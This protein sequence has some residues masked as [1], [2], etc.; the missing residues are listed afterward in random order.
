MREQ[1]I[2]LHPF[3]GGMSSTAIIPIVRREPPKRPILKKTATTE[4]TKERGDSTISEQRSRNESK[5][6]TS[7]PRKVVKEHSL[8]KMKADRQKSKSKQNEFS[9]TTSDGFGNMK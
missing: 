1:C 8:L 6:G 5:R 4:M 2:Y 3:K 9:K 7:M